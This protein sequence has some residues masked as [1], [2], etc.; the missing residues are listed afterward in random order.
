MCYTSIVLT[1]PFSRDMLGGRSLHRGL[2][3]IDA[4]ISPVPDYTTGIGV[5]CARVR[6]AGGPSD[7]YFTADSAHGL[8]GLHCVPTTDQSSR[9][10]I[11]SESH[12]VKTFATDLW[13]SGVQWSSYIFTPLLCLTKNSPEGSINSI[14]SFEQDS[15]S[16]VFQVSL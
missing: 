10:L 15:I 13:P 5:S 4:V 1:I 8:A 2:F 3:K 12:S 6:A 11:R 9:F 14:P 16:H 7:G